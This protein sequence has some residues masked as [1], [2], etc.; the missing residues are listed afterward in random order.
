MAK[1]PKCFSRISL[2]DD[3]QYVT[4]TCP[5]CGTSFEPAG[6]APPANPTPPPPAVQAEPV[7][8]PTMQQ[9]VVATPVEAGVMEGISLHGQV[10]MENI[11][12]IDHQET[13]GSDMPGD[14]EMWSGEKAVQAPDSTAVNF[15]NLTQ[16]RTPDSQHKSDMI[17]IAMQQKALKRRK[18]WLIVAGIGILANLI[19]GLCIWPHREA[20]KA[21][22]ENTF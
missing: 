10:N 15:G 7:S 5:S 3:Q 22:L 12:A 20:I 9:A 1:C 4:Q 17:S 13:G 21:W 2:E 6:S 18:T 16:P 11:T 8:I 19:L 14:D